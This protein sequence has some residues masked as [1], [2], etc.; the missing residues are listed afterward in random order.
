[1]TYVREK[2]SFD[3]VIAKVR[4]LSFGFQVELVLS[5]RFSLIIEKK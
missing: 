4:R 3:L 5:V 1:M 2:K